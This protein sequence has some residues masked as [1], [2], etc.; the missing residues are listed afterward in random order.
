MIAVRMGARPWKFVEVKA[1]LSS[2]QTALVTSQI[3]KDKIIQSYGFQGITVPPDPAIP[4]QQ[5]PTQVELYRV[6][7]YP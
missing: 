6:F 3:K 2:S 7:L 5:P 4:I 1:S